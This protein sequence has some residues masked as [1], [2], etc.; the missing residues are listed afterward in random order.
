[1]RRDEV[2]LS[3]KQIAEQY[4]VNKETARRWIMRILG[5]DERITPRKKGRGVRPYRLRR[6]PQSLLEKHLD[7]FLNG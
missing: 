6:I 7:E 4:S 2:W 1:M 5:D 3:P